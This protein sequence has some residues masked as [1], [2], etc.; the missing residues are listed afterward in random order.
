MP[1][2]KMLIDSDITSEWLSVAVCIRTYSVHI[3]TTT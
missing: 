2:Y 1:K 3:R